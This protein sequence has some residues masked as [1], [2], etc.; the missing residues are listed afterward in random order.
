M[1]LSPPSNLLCI[2]VLVNGHVIVN[3]KLNYSSN[4]VCK[5]SSSLFIQYGH[6]ASTLDAIPATIVDAA[7]TTA[8]STEK[9]C[10][11]FQFQDRIIKA[12]CNLLFN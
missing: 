12:I 9:Y 2:N 3:Y 10:I 6:A 4:I 8:R 7:Q 11:F 1:H 5:D